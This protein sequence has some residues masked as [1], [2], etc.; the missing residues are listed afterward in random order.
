MIN[1]HPQDEP[2]YVGKIGERHYLYE[3]GLWVQAEFKRDSWVRK[4][5][6]DRQ[7]PKEIMHKLHEDYKGKKFHMSA[8][9]L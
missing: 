4:Y 9:W 2:T 5:V 3:H 7:V 8:R 1:Y 6:M